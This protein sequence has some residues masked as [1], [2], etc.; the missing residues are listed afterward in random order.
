MWTEERAG[1]GVLQPR[2]LEPRRDASGRSSSPSGVL[3]FIINVVAHARARRTV[4]RRSTRGTPVRCEWMTTSPPKE[5]NFDALPDVHALDEFFHRKDEDVGEGRLQRPAA[6][7]DGRGDPRRAG[8][9]RRP[10]HRT[11]RR[12]RTGLIVAGPD[13][14]DHRL[15]GDLHTSHRHRRRGDP[16]CSPRSA[17]RSSRRLPPTRDDEAPAGARATDWPTDGVMPAT[18]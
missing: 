6:G 14:A 13:A 7:G 17:G 18:R 15:R 12:C 4:G 5:H 3:V 9:Q 16:A 1:E 2:L 10:P 8:G 11:C